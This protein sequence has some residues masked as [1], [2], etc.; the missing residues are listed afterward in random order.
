MRLTMD[1]RSGWVRACETGRKLR[2]RFPRRVR[3]HAGAAV[4]A[5][6]LLTA[7]PVAAAFAQPSVDPV[8]TGQTQPGLSHEAAGPVEEEHAG[9]GIIDVLAR[10]VNFGILAGT[11]YYFL[12]GP[13][14]TYFT[15]RSTRIRSDLVAAAAMRDEATRQLAEI[16]ER[17][18]ALPGELDALRRQGTEEIAAEQERIRAAAAAERTRLVEQARREIDLQVKVAERALVARAAELAVGTAAD[19]IRRAITPDDR[20]RLVDRYVHQMAE[21]TQ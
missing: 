9:R 11:L 8:A 10:L 15:D 16:E 1:D 17:M 19:R 21:R 4:V 5:L 12:R 20:R 7:T 3:R 13:V 2:C 14:R 6:A 18:K